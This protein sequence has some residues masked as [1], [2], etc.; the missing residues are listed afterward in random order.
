M[1][2]DETTPSPTKNTLIPNANEERISP[3]LP[4]DEEQKQLAESTKLKTAA[5]SAFT[6]GEY[7][8]ALEGYSRAIDACPT[9]LDY[10]LAVLQ[11]NMAAC[12][13]KLEEWK[14]ATERATEAIDGLQRLDPV[15]KP[16]N[17]EKRETEGDNAAEESVVEVDDAMEERLEALTRTGRSLDD[18]RKLRTK[19]LLRRAKA[20]SEL[21]TWAELQGAMDG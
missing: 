11:S 3:V 2:S 15:A 8:G 10:D 5:N 20:R 12:C 7:S 17:P 1:T 19:A 4:L 9:Y 6:S 18:V 16:Q 13:L 14:K 21:G